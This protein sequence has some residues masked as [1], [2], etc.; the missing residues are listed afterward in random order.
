MHNTRLAR[1]SVICFSVFAVLVA[2]N[3]SSSAQKSKKKVSVA[4]ASG[5]ATSTDKSPWL[6]K[7]KGA[8][9]TLPEF[10]A[11]YQRMN[12]RAPYATTLDSLKDFLSIYADYRLKLQEAKEE[13][14]D[15]DPKI[16]KEIEG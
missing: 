6:I 2:L 10:E 8:S 16:L 15:K 4:G 5:A 13:G 7:W 11:A 1:Y 14:L 9:V 12:G 3:T